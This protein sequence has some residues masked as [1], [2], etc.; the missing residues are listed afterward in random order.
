[1]EVPSGYPCVTIAMSIQIFIKPE[2]FKRAI[3]R[4]KEMNYSIVEQLH[5]RVRKNK[6][7]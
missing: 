4:N 3:L 1:L 6:K 7:L 2:I 5:V